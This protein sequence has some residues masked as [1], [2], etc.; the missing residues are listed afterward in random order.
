MKR[1]FERKAQLAA[2]RSLEFDVLVVGGGATGL[3]IAVDAASRGYRTALVEAHDFAKGT[4]SRSTKLV[5]GGVRYLEQLHFSLVREALEERAILCENAPHLV[6]DLPFVVPRYRWWEGPF[7]GAGLKLYDALAGSRGFGRSRFLDREETIRAI[8][9]VREDGLLGGI[10]YR[11]GQFDDA[12]MALALARTAASHGAA[13]ANRLRCTG[14]V[15]SDGRV[16]GIEA[17]DG[18]RDGEP[19]V[20][21]PIRAAVVV[22]A[23]GVF[24]D[25]VRRL[26]EPGSPG[27]LEPSRGV[28]LVLP[29]RFLPGGH[30]IMVPHTDDG[31]VLFVIPWHGRTLVGTTDVEVKDPEIEPRASE[32]EIGF[33]LR[34]A[35]RYL[36]SEP[37]RGDVLSV[38][39]GLRPLV[40]PAGATESRQV[41]R[42]HAIEVSGSGLVTI[43]GGKWTTYRRMAEEAVE[44]ACE[45]GGLEVRAGRTAELRL[46]GYDPTSA[47]GSGMPGLRALYG[48]DRAAIEEIERSDPRLAG[49]IHPELPITGSELVFAA[50][51]EMARSVEDLL[52]RR[53]RALLL[54][55]R[56]AIAVA[57]EVA[58]LV[59]P[60]LGWSAGDAVASAEEFRA[61]AR[62]YLPE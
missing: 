45:T 28:H 34:N 6:H 4:S 47:A 11:D 22:N 36:A 32:E 38:F 16:V 20:R 24:A 26:D 49:P 62:G 41:S 8:P 57:D 58:R 15:K 25:G 61:I 3:G 50:R 5:H 33:V 9:G 23:T 30:A 27:R 37:T 52:A 31:R 44:V 35:G 1:P 39:A 53:T 21:F 56:A 43:T 48:T 19:G 7:Y 40:R 18:E 14:L 55:A 29:R 13:I 17:C 54:D 60:E 10:E 46:H 51:A 2:L 42:E 12:R 59:A